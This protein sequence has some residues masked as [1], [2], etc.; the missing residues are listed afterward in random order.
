M[1][2]ANKVR[3]AVLSGGCS[4][5]HEVSLRSAANVMQFLDSSRFEIIPIGID[6]Q[7]KW[8]LDN[9]PN[10]GDDHPIW[11]T[12]DVIFPV[13]HGTL[14][15]DGTLQGLL[16][17]TNLPYVGCG[18]LASA[19][20]MDKDVSKRLA[21]GAGIPV[22][23][24]LVIK[25]DQ[26]Q[27]DADSF[28]QQVMEKLAYPVFVKPANTGSSIGITKVKTPA[29]L[30]AAINEAFRFDVKVLVEKA[31]NVIEIELA[32]L[33][34]LENSDPIISVV[35]EIRPRHEFY[36]YEAKYTDENGAELLI[37]A[38]ITNELKEKARAIAREIFLVL[39]CEGMA[40]VDL[41]IEKETQQI[42]FNE[43]NTIPGFTQISMYPKLMEAS[44]ISY[45]QL[46]THLID[47]AM[48]RHTRKRELIRSYV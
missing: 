38:P 2:L 39:E 40:R 27:R 10:L 28:S 24:Y 6:K 12:F 30:K 26:W 34:S 7:G 42:Y 22:A 41:F 48:K 25:Q 17:L 21:M 36:S 18:V 11:H 46:L 1:K 31:L 32:A 4:A 44:G 33:E 29:Q 3:V 19:I 45:S 35:G 9:M 47:L 8:F 14:C 37:P 43:I 20:G 13:V 5:E 23:P 16:E 15:E